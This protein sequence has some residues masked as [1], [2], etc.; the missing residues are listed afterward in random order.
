MPFKFIRFITLLI[1]VMSLVYVGQTQ[2]VYGHEPYL[3]PPQFHVS[4]WDG[5]PLANMDDDPCALDPRDYRDYSDSSGNGT[6]SAS[7]WAL[8]YYGSS[9]ISGKHDSDDEVNLVFGARVDLSASAGNSSCSRYLNVSLL[10][11]RIHMS[12]L[13]EMLLSIRIHRSN[14]LC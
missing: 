8:R 11:N 13:L 2:D 14:P 9:L 3:H 10:L 7:S 1:F 6:E 5:K 12:P 4:S